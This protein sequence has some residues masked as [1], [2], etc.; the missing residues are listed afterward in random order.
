[1]SKAVLN[2]AII[3]TVNDKNVAVLNT[4]ITINENTQKQAY[5]M[6]LASLP[7][8]D[9]F[10][11]HQVDR[12]LSNILSGDHLDSYYFFY[13]FDHL[14]SICVIDGNKEDLRAYI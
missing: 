9:N 3:A 13:H 14:V 7:D 2:I 5:A 4:L 6:I 1:M 8:H 11:P 12:M 10:L